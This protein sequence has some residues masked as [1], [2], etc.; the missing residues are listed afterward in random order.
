MPPSAKWTFMV[1]IAG[2]NNLSAAGDNDLAEMRQVGST[3][4]VNVVAQFD[5]A[6]TFGTRRFHIQRDGRNEVVEHLDETDSGSPEVLLG[7]IDWVAEDYPAD[8]YAL[9]LWNHGGGWEP[10]EIDRI[11]R[12]V[13]ATDFSEREAS[14]RSSTPL[15]R[16]FFRT[17]LQRIFEG[18]TPTERAV[19]SD[20]GTGHSLDTLELEQVMSRAVERLGCKF[21]LLG[22]DA[23]LMSNYEVAYQLRDSALFLVASEENEPNDGWPYDRVLARLVESPEMAAGDLA[24]HIVDDYVASYVERGYRGAVTQCALDLSRVEEL[25]APLDDLAGALVAGMPDAAGEIWRSQRLSA[26]FAHNTLWDIANFCGQIGAGSV[27]EPIQEAASSVRAALAPGQES[28]VLAEAHHGATVEHCGGVNLYLVPPL[29]RISPY[30]RELAFAQ[31]RHW[32]EM[33][34]AYHAQ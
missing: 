4:E 16:V 32:L 31:D 33:L 22:M 13:G 2:D 9:V 18:S 3:P 30:Y 19:C 21:D 28:P 15:R 12:A 1:Y 29:V 24:R 8:H 26:R 25:A 23:C 11:A 5:N 10:A 7:F 6:G 14:E 17:S 34:E 20:D 27:S